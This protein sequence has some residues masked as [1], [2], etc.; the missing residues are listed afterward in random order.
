MLTWTL[1]FL[2]AALAAALLGIKG[3]A[4]AAAGLTIIS[5]VFLTSLFLDVF[6]GGAEHETV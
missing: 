2:V 5:I 4:T 1:M 3:I 6:T